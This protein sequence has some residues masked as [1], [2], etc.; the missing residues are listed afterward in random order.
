MVL[1][2]TTG[3]APPAKMGA[4]TL[5]VDPYSWVV[6]TRPGEVDVDAI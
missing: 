5:W 1:D 4:G 2:A 3:A 6:R